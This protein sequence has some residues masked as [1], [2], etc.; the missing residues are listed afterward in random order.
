MDTP[1]PT[2]TLAEAANFTA[3]S[4]G[5]RPSEYMTHHGMIRNWW[6]K[7]LLPPADIEGDSGRARIDLE[8]LCAIPF[9]TVLAD[10]GQDVRA[11]EQSF[12]ALRTFAEIGDGRSESGV[13]VAADSAINHDSKQWF[14]H[15]WSTGRGFA[16]QWTHNEDDPRGPVGKRIIDDHATVT[17]STVSRTV[18][19]ATPLL[20]A[21]F[22]IMDSEQVTLPPKAE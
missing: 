3:E 19:A 8:T 18:I 2:F 14:F 6:N 16:G 1:T 13:K 21:L 7:R 5:K 12:R 11:L 10:M 15:L 4:V 17:G 9:L 22:R 20:K